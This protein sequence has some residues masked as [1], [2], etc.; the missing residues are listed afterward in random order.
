MIDSEILKHAE[1]RILQFKELQKNGF[2]NL[3]GEFFPSVHYP[4]IT[5]YPP[6]TNE[7]LFA[8]YQNPT[9]DLFD[10]YVH[11]PFCM[12]YCSFCHYPVKI[13][14]SD[15]EKDYYLR[16]LQQEMD[17]SMR[18]LGVRKIRARSILIGGG[19]PTNLTPVQLERFLIFFKKRVDIS[20]CT[21]FSYD[22]DPITMIADDGV[23]L[24][25]LKDHGVDRLTIGCQSFDDAVL[26]LMNRPHN[27][28]EALRAI[29]DSRAAGFKLNIEFIYG[30]SGQTIEQWLDML[31]KAVSMGVEEIQLYRLKITPY[32]DHDGAIHKKFLRSEEDFLTPEQAL[33]MKAAAE[34]YL[35]QQ[36]HHENLRRVFSKT[37]EDFSHYADNQC[38]GLLDQIGFGLTGFSSLHDRFGLNTLDF[39]KYYCL[40][41]DGKLPADRGVVRGREDQMRWALVLPLKNRKVYKKYFHQ[42]TGESLDRVFRDKVEPLKKF[43][44]L[45]ENEKVLKLTSLGGFFAD[46][47]CHQF[48]KPEYIPFSRREYADG[49]LNPYL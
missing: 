19:T 41:N 16:M 27:T 38:C 13:N 2:I 47:V 24:K 9:G 43:G 21:Q 44:L 32:G 36:G 33:R 28:E 48:H 23:R 1:E 37:R 6:I 34:V 11:I 15:E 40:I 10:I 31:E 7:A 30:Y 14:S 8:G 12:T 46:E 4:P 22:V 3:R 26:K 49:E 42:L 25:I 39:Q 18:I 29:R 5:M 20:S 35:P 45:Q 17:I